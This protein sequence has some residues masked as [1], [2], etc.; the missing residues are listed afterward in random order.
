MLTQRPVLSA[1]TATFTAVALI[2]LAA[3]SARAEEEVPLALPCRPTI[4]C[5]AE[6][7]PE[8][9]LEIETGWLRRIQRDAR[10]VDAT[11]VLLKLSLTDSLQLQ[12]GTNGLVFGG[13]GNVRYLDDVVVGA[14]V[15]LLPQ[16]SLAP[17][18]SLS[19]ALSIPTF[20]GQPGYARTWDVISTL[21]VTKDFPWSLHADL[22][23]GL[24]LW[25]LEYK[26][27]VQQELA[28]AISR[29]VFKGLPF[30]AMVEV[31][32]FTDASPI[33]PR[34]AGILVG[35]AWTVWRNLVLD[36]GGDLELSRTQSASLFAGLTWTPGR[37]WHPHTSNHSRPWQTA[38]GS[39]PQ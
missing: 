39:R 15:L 32:G 12:A 7:V 29:P 37:L 24:A 31:Y 9:T 19:G 26:P 4:A 5:T 28:L 8:G 35:L 25:R 20:R 30:T 22:N 1:A 3:G 11:P 13:G 27:L 17:A 2:G 16:S 33:A 18:L 34:D 38:S 23:L 36:A 6:F 21:Y 10:C 14:K